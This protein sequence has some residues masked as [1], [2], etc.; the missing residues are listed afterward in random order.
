[1]SRFV[2]PAHSLFFLKWRKRLQRFRLTMQSSFFLEKNANALSKWQAEVIQ[3]VKETSKH[4][5]HE[6]FELTFKYLAAD[7][8]SPL[9]HLHTL[10]VSNNQ[11]VSTEGL[12]LCPTIQHLDLSG[13]YLTAIKGVEKLGL[14]LEL[15]ASSNNLSEVSPEY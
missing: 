14:L 3:A 9:R 11:L 10:L 15:D 1:M 13:N 8:L 4:K 2:V 12:D 5:K 7:G 6:H